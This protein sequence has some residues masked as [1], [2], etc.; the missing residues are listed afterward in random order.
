MT[1]N[2]AR[3]IGRRGAGTWGRPAKPYKKR[4]SAKAVRRA[5]KKETANG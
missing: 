1:N 5:R 3:K 4:L 2:L